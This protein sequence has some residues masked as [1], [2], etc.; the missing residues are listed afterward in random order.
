MLKG[1]Q[2]F[3]LLILLT[4]YIKNCFAAFD[5]LEVGAR[6]LGMGGASTAVTGG[7]SAIGYNPAGL[8]QGKSEFLAMGNNLYGI[9]I[10][11]NY[12]GLSCST[13]FGDIAVG[14][15]TI[16][17]SAYNYKEDTVALTYT[18]KPLE[19]LGAGLTVNKYSG[20]SDVDSEGVGFDLGFIL[21]LNKI[22]LGIACYGL[23]KEIKYKNGFSE[24]Y[25]PVCRVGACYLTAD[26]LFAFDYEQGLWFL[27]CEKVF[28]DNL[29][30][31]GGFRNGDLTL[32]FSLKTGRLTFDYAFTSYDLNY[33]HN[34]SAR[35][36]LF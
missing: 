8:A 1:K 9:G 29:A 33:D 28:T 5:R 24:K 25:D 34:I 16:D 6:A 30:L 3:I 4:L 27:G 19:I 10:Q 7:I 23:G 20:L 32:G 17:D 31:R 11:N 14:K 2:M 13:K 35:F 21:R 36:S 22:N 12:L 26:M 15:S 18:I